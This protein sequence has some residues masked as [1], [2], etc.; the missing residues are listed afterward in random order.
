VTLEEIQDQWDLIV[1]GG[2]I[3]GAGVFREAVRS[4]LKV[5]LLESGDFSRGTS[6]RSAK[7]VHGGLRYLKEGRIWLTRES[8]RARQRLLMEAP[9]L[10]EP[11]EFLM[12]VYEGHGPGRWA[13]EAGLSVYD[14]MA[15][16][17]Q[18]TYYSAEE[19][20]QLV[21]SIRTER[22]SGGFSF[23]DAQVDDSRLVLRLIYEAVDAGAVALNYTS[24][25]HI[26]RNDRGDVVGVVAEDSET[27]EAREF[28]AR[29][30]VNAT[31]AWAERLHPSPE[32]RRHLR[33]LRGSHL[34][35]PLSVLPVHRAVSFMHPTDKRPIYATPWE[36]A[37]IFGTTDV[38]HKEDL[39]KE[40][41]ITDEE[42]S[43][44]ME[45]LRFFF[46][47]LDISL[48]DCLSTFS[49]IRPVL[50]EGKLSP[51]EESREHVVWVDKGLITVTG[52]KL[53][54]FRKLAWDTLDAVRP[55]MAGMQLKGKDDPAFAPGPETPPPATDLASDYRRRLQ[56][57]YGNHATEIVEGTEAALLDP[58]PGT[59]TLWAE[60]PFAAAREHVRHLSDLLL[61]RVRIGLLTPDGGAGH[62][63]RIQEICQDVLPWDEVRWQ[64]EKRMYVETWTRAY[65]VPLPERQSVE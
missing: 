42:V 44:L 39:D 21:P 22:L 5:L 26:V 61:R 40:P 30:V 43:Y 49:G 64:E 17:R 1:V 54:T 35:F 27:H 13:L 29:A 25:R 4:G 65:S 50:S 62:L 31:G 12:P 7:L 52:G 6:S 11:L 23:L 20:S 56:G 28:S 36:G 16:K 47:R 32:P 63:S 59:H 2:G 55:C 8:V 58:I 46:P 38:D 33:P 10:V 37:V 9:G 51:S 60:L 24:V 3:T 45:S 19:F 18:H 57:R 15:L 34:V 14:L 41:A 53:T 48:S